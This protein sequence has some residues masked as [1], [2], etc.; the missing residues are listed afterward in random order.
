MNALAEDKIVQARWQ[1]RYIKNCQRYTLAR[2][3]K[4]G[5]VPGWVWHAS[6]RQPP[7]PFHAAAPEPGRC[8]VCGGSTGSRLTWDPKCVI[9]Y[10]LWTK[11]GNYALPIVVG[12]E[13]LCA[14]TSVPIGP[15]AAPYLGDDVEIDHDVPIYRVRRDMTDKPWFELLRFWGLANLRALS[16][17]AHVAKCAAEAKERSGRRSTSPDQGALL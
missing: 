3:R 7:L 16:R 4:S 12:Q 8:R 11:P 15:P 5:I 2:C 1:L 13:G 10:T 9:T 14:V 6:S 17:A